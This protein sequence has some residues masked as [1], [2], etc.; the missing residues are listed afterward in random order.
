MFN[1]S[2]QS[3]HELNPVSIDVLKIYKD[4]Y[5]AKYLNRVYYPDFKLR[6]REKEKPEI[7]VYSGIPIK[8]INHDLGRKWTF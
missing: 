8:S 2:E 4:S 7:T 3:W 6:V 1:R 5:S